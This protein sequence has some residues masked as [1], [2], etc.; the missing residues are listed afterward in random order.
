MASEKAL[1]WV[2]LGVAA[3]FLGSHFAQRYDG[4]CLA[5]R[6]LAAVQELSAEASQLMASAG[7][8]LDRSSLPLVD[9]ESEVARFQSQF[10][11]MD[12]AIARE[13]SACARMQA[14][15]AR[16]MALREVQHLR[17]ET[18]CPRQALRLQVPTA[19]PDSTL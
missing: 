15:Q 16:R 17:L 5:K 10:A 11:S 4:G 18:V 12:A 9:A 6:S 1:Y 3:L 8:V 19:R 14:Q 13:Q 2:A 7:L